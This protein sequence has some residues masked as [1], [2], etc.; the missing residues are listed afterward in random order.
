MIVVDSS[1]W[2]A[3]FRGEPSPS[4]AKLDHVVDPTTLLVGDLVLFEVLQ[5]ARDERHAERIAR[6][7][8]AFDAVSMT[9]PGLALAAAR[10]SRFLRSR[11]VT[12]RKTIDL[13][14]ATFCIERGH[15]LL[16]QDRDFDLIA[17]HL[18]LAIA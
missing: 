6:A 16:H 12:I 15:A 11:G 9:D 8:G 17:Q 5:G 7:L 13:L 4:V 10:Y 18:P 14:I 3:R 1:V 2:I